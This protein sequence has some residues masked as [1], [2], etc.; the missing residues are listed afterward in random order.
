[1]L[2]FDYN[3]LVDHDHQPENILLA[4]GTMDAVVKVTDFGLAKLVGPQSFMKTMCGTPDYLA[5]EVLKTGM[6]KGAGSVCV[7]I[8]P[9]WRCDRCAGGVQ[10]RRG[11]VESWCYLVHLVCTWTAS[12]SLPHRCSVFRAPLRSPRRLHTTES[13]L[14]S[15]FSAPFT[16]FPTKSGAVFPRAVGAS[17][18]SL[19]T[20]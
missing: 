2:A 5:P 15:R 1:M 17:H 11:H 3:F 16:R 10:R 4:N 7:F 13:R 19:I 18:P 12:R 8:G 6:L 20:V 9:V 14:R